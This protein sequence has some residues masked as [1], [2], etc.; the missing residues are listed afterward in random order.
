MLKVP[1]GEWLARCKPDLQHL[2]ILSKLNKLNILTNLN[3]L[4]KV[5][6]LKKLRKV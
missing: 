2:N 5:K 3:K 6:N 1:T 4:Y